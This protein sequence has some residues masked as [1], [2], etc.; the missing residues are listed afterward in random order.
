MFQD[1]ASVSVHN[2]KGQ[3]E[4]LHRR[5]PNVRLRERALGQLRC[6]GAAGTLHEE[7]RKL[8]DEYRN[9]DPV[10]KRQRLETWRHERAGV[11]A[12]R[13]EEGEPGDDGVDSNDPVD[14]HWGMGNGRWPVRPE[15]VDRET[16]LARGGGVRNAGN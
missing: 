5:E 14:S 12:A 10:A 13:A 1:L 6:L 11:Q 15:A 2:A 16:L 3:A 8:A 7:R 9:L 4:A